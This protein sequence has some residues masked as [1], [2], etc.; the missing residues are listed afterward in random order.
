[1]LGHHVPTLAAQ[2]PRMAAAEVRLRRLRLA[3]WASCSGITS[4]GLTPTMGRQVE[5]GL[6]ACAPMSPEDPAWRRAILEILQGIAHELT[7]MMQPLCHRQGK[8]DVWW[9]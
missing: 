7:Q 6:K 9:L 5:P 1:V 4:A 3:L 8:R 2:F